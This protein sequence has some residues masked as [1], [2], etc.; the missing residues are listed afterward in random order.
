MTAK[1]I[2]N[3]DV[4][5]ERVRAAGLDPHAIKNAEEFRTAIAVGVPEYLERATEGG[6]HDQAAAT[7]DAMSAVV[8]ELVAILT[9]LGA[10]DAAIAGALNRVLTLMA[11]FSRAVALV[12]IAKQRIQQ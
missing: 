8:D 6:Y 11:E 5:D 7:I 2:P 4:I 1:Q 3:Q 9:E 12:E 10:D